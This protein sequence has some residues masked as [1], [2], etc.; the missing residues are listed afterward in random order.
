[1]KTIIVATDFSDA[2]ENAINYAAEM[3][4][5][6]KAR[7]ILF[8]A[9]QIPVAV[10][11]MPVVYDME[12]L[13]ADNKRQ[14]DTIKERLQ[15]A[16]GPALFLQT[17]VSEGSLIGCLKD[18]CEDMEPYAV[19]M[20][21]H[22]TTAAERF[23]FGSNTVY[24]LKHLHWPIIAVPANFAFAGIKKIAFASDLDKDLAKTALALL[25]NWVTDFMA[26]LHI[27]NFGKQEQFYEN[28]VFASGALQRELKVLDPQFHFIT[29]ENTEDAITQFVLAN[30][31]DLLVVLHKTYGFFEN[32]FHKSQ[33]KQFALY[34]AIPLLV[35]HE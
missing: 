7:L 20:G 19:V 30:Q 12:A 32:I 11:E 22:G 14:L 1:M 8:H 5:Q 35:L 3:A 29:G 31:I 13:I 33:T 18:I 24:A 4:L 6:L 15:D 2:A 27:V 23:F 10:S 26:G 16:K 17:E 28:S 25:K 21:S 34:S 9:Y